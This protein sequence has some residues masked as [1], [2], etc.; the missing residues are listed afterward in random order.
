MKQEQR[1]LLNEGLMMLG[2]AYAIDGYHVPALLAGI[3][4]FLIAMKGHVEEGRKYAYPIL[5]ISFMELIIIR[6]TNL[7]SI[8][9]MVGILTV[10]NTA[11][12]FLW[13]DSPFS[14]MDRMMKIMMTIMLMMYIITMII[15]SMDL[16]FMD[17]IVYISLIFLPMTISYVLRCMKDAS[18]SH[19]METNAV[20]R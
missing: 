5:V 7:N 20:M 16:G 15:P 13:M 1:L 3:G 14:V 19:Y 2:F 6:F 17:A 11:V 9:P 18:R 4:G 10:L 8:A 12:C